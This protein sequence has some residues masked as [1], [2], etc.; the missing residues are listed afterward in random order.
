MKKIKLSNCEKYALV[1]DDL[2]EELNKRSWRLDV[3]GYVRTGNY[4]RMHRII[5]KTPKGML[6]DHINGN[7]LDNRL[8]NLR[9]CTNQQNQANRGAPV[10]NRSGYKG[11]SQHHAGASFRAAI[12]HHNKF[13]H[14]GAYPTA[15]EA[16]RAYDEKAREFWGEYAYQN[17]PSAGT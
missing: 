2:F 4:D 3:D 15:E 12:T 17:F 9:N 8:E 10:N 11:V 6:T 7:K 5:A 14:I 16:A 1:D 13:I